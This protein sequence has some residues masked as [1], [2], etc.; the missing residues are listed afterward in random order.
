MDSPRQCTVRSIV[1]FLAVLCLGIGLSCGP[2]LPDSYG[3]YAN[4]NRGRLRLEGEGILARGSLFSAV[5][6][7][8]GPTGVECGSLESFIV[9]RKDV[10]PDAIAVS[11]LEFEGVVP[12]RGP[13]G[14]SRELI[15]LWVPKARV[16]IDVKPVE[17]H[18]DMYLAIPREPLPKGFY[19]LHL[20]RFGSELPI[21]GG[22]AYDIV[23]GA[24]RDFPTHEATVHDRREDIRKAA[25]DLLRAMNQ[26]FSSR[27]F[28]RLGEVYR[29]HGLPLAGSALEEFRK[30]NDTW[31]G[32]AGRIVRSEIT[33]VT[34]DENGTNARC[35][36]QT[37]YEKIGQ[38][39]ES[40]VV[41]KIGDRFFITE[42][43]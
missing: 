6:G 29:P 20:G 11:R 28:A 1:A 2:S 5:A 41:T 13:F 4:T 18:S 15:N 24:A 42:M 21:M 17:G 8:K 14:E 31:F 3:I 23:V 39:A 34:P 40:L 35:T 37:T 10:T 26:M 22:V 43:N 9:Y 27:S 30:G 19:T 32:N 12:V 25:G 33:T 36:V 16:E 38:Q 7:L